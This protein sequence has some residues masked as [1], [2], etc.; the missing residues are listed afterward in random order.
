MNGKINWDERIMGSVFELPTKLPGKSIQLNSIESYWKDKPLVLQYFGLSPGNP[1]TSPVKQEVA[2]NRQHRVGDKPASVF[3]RSE[4]RF[5]EAIEYSSTMAVRESKISDNCYG[6]S[7]EGL[8]KISAELFALDLINENS[9]QEASTVG[10]KKYS[11]SVISTATT[12]VTPSTGRAGDDNQTSSPLLEL[13]GHK[14]TV[15]LFSQSRLRTS[16][17]SFSSFKVDGQVR[18]RE[19]S[20]SLSEYLE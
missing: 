10:Q 7:R 11:G 3:L 6:H 19:I 14:A 20:G 13:D 2:H 18:C 12:T 1:Q 5:Q 9:E 4:S 17:A 8:L 15:T 16:P